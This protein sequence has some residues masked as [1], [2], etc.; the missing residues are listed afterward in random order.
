MKLIKS[1]LQ[2][3]SPEKVKKFIKSLNKRKSI[4]TLT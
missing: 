2:E 4:T 1:E 3:V